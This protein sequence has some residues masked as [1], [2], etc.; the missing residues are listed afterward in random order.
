[1]EL[2]SNT[3]KGRRREEKKRRGNPGALKKNPC[4]ITTGLPCTRRGGLGPLIF[5]GRIPSQ[6]PYQIPRRLLERQRKFQTMGIGA[7]MER[8]STTGIGDGLDEEGMAEMV[9]MD[10]EEKIWILSLLD[11]YCTCG[12][13]GANA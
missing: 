13:V 11:T 8:W 9:S 10:L 1:M 12:P 3:K 4:N 2:P 5:P 7:N 6:R